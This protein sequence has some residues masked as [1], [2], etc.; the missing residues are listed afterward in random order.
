MLIIKL[1]QA[2][3]N[4]RAISSYRFWEVKMYSAVNSSGCL[5]DGCSGKTNGR[6]GNG[7]SFW[8]KA[9]SSSAKSAQE[10]LPNHSG[11]RFNQR[12]EFSWKRPCLPVHIPKYMLCPDI[13]WFVMWKS[14]IK[15][16][17]LPPGF[18]FQGISIPMYSTVP[19]AAKTPNYFLTI[20][21][22]LAYVQSH[23]RRWMIVYHFYAEY[24]KD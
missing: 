20:A 10:E 11:L 18:V 21:K 17:V 8:D 5:T 22:N 7:S 13:W 9:H 23:M 15:N 24:C 4:F 2:Y 14:E 3:P 19:V 6:E 16:I 12:I 1:I